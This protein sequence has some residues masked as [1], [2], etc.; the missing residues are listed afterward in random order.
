MIGDKKT[1]YKRWIRKQTPENWHDY[2]Q[3]RDKTK[4]MVAEAKAKTWSD[5]GNQLESNY[6]SA[7]KTFWQTIRRLRK[8]GQ[9]STR[10]VKDTN[11]KLLIQ[12]EEI[13]NRWKEYFA[14]LYNPISGQKTQT[15]KPASDESN[16]ITMAEVATAIKSLKSGKAAGVDE[17]RPEMLKSLGS[18][19]ILWLTRICR[20]V[21]KTGKAPADWQTGVVV[22]IFKN[23]DQRDC[24]NYRGITLL[25]LPGKVFARIIERRC[26]E[27]IEPKIQDIQCGFRPGRG[28]TD[29]IFT[30]QQTLE[31]AWEF[32]KPVYSLFIDLEKAYDRVPRKKLWD[33]LKEYGIHGRL[34]AAIQ[35]LYNNCKSC[36][37]INGSNSDYFQVQVGLCQGCVLSPLLFIVFM[38]KISRISD[39]PAGIEIGNVKVDSLLFADDVAR[40][41]TSEEG[42][43]E[44]LNQFDETC[45]TFGMKISTKKTELM[46]VSREPKQCN[47]QLNNNP[48]NQVSKFKYLGVQFSSDGKQNGEID[49]RIGTASGVLRSL[50]RSL[51]T[52]K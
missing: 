11:G 15:N 33:V 50:Y 27:I 49:R 29:Q 1:A 48:L 12:E 13:L 26:R 36:V 17:I 5:F 43:Q 18:G 34:L 38:D 23:G 8:G 28:T 25:S 20:L 14:D 39:N 51:V 30:L 52:I 31:K 9:K 16:D 7:S 6:H 47:L 35:S 32:A 24:S 46:T 3:K 41:S 4:K 45:S 22:P 37:R 44:A 10:S 42:L 19:D 21:W 40:L 2:K